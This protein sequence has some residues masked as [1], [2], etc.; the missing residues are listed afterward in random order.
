MRNFIRRRG[1][2]GAEKPVALD[3]AHRRLA[4]LLASTDPATAARAVLAAGQPCSLS[5][6]RRRI[7]SL[8]T[9]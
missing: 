6:A 7:K 1:A 4:F 5:A 2:L 8:A 3:A 9:D